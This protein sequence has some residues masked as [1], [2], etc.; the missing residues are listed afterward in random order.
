MEMHLILAECVNYGKSFKNKVKPDG[1]VLNCHASCPRTFPQPISLLET[2]IMM[3]SWKNELVYDRMGLVLHVIK[4]DNYKTHTKQM[5]DWHL[6]KRAY[7]K[8][9]FFSYFA[10]KT[11]VLGTQKNRLKMRR[12]F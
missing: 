1:L 7:Q 11:S 10:T 9:I 8:K 3:W 6:V 12:F 2:C 5:S 4:M